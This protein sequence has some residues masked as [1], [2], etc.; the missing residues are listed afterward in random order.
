MHGSTWRTVAFHSRTMLAAEL[1]YEVFDK[2]L[3]A[4]VDCFKAWRHLLILCQEEI[5]VLADHK[6]LLYFAKK[7]KLNQRQY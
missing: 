4:I 7:L 1:N 2:E 6:N 3:L 5:L